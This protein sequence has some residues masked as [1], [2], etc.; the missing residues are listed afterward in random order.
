MYKGSLPWQNIQ[1]KS[2][3]EKYQKILEKKINV[4]VEELCQGMPEEFVTLVQ[5]IRN[6]QFE[7]VP[8]YEMMKNKLKNVLVREKMTNDWGFDWIL[9]DN[10]ISN[11]SNIEINKTIN[12]K[13]KLENLNKQNS[14]NQKNEEIKNNKLIGKDE[15][16]K[17]KKENDQNMINNITTNLSTG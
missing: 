11:N 7:E 14:N 8:D 16:L 10:N 13:N 3:H 15:K 1:A 6:L 9:N 4:G 2:K 17:D 5:Y 12:D